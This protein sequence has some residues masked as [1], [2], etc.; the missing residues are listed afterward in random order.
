MYQGFSILPSNPDIGRGLMVLS[1]QY[2][3]VFAGLSILLAT[4]LCLSTCLFLC[5][6]VHY[7]AYCPSCGRKAGKVE[8]ERCAGGS[9]SGNDYTL[10]VWYKERICANCD[11]VLS[12]EPN[13]FEVVRNR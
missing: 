4:V 12:R 8:R 7:A 3:T 2:D 9:E 11:R 13:G 5:F 6:A 1:A 10:V